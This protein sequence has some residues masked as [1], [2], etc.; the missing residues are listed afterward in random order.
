MFSSPGVEN[1]RRKAFS[2]VYV[3]S[4]P[5]IPPIPPSLSSGPET[6]F[7]LD[8]QYLSISARKDVLPYR[9]IEQPPMTQI[10]L[11]IRKPGRLEIED[12]GT[13]EVPEIPKPG[14]YISVSELDLR[15]P[16]SSDFIVR[17]VWW[18]LRRADDPEGVGSTTEIMVEADIAVG[19]YASRHWQQRAQHIRSL[20]IPIEN[21]EVSRITL[22]LGNDISDDGAE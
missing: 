14:D 12:S 4:I 6:V 2:R 18:R 9:T 13:F 15:D 8:S 19:P 3:Y 11:C 21:F 10:I 22:G 17:H 16:L 1:A 5:P 7:L 20:G